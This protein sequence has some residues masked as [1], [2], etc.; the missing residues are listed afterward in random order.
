[1]LVNFKCWRKCKVL[2]TNNEFVN[3]TFHFSRGQE[4][5]E[6]EEKIHDQLPECKMQYN[7]K[8]VELN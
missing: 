7:L 5:K 3:E 6:V 1:M 2:L 8:V 4:G